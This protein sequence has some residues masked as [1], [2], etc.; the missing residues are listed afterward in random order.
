MASARAQFELARKREAQNKELSC[1][2][3]ATSLIWSRPKRMR[4]SWRPMSR[5]GSPGKTNWDQ[6]GAFVRSDQAQVAQVK[7][8]LAK[9]R[10]DLDQTTVRAPADGTPIYVQLWAGS[11]VLILPFTRQ[12][13]AEDS[14]QVITYFPAERAYAGR[15]R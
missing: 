8:D 6:I 10:W 7:A 12:E 4:D 15:S 9:A 14:Q 11:L 5:L 1:P 3:Q 2:V 13:L